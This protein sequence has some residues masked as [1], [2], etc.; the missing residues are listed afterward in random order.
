[1]FLCWFNFINSIN[2]TVGFLFWFVLIFIIFRILITRKLVIFNVLTG[3]ICFFSQHR[4]MH[5]SVL[6]QVVLSP[7]QSFAIRAFILLPVVNIYIVPFPIPCLLENFST[8]LASMMFLLPLEVLIKMR[9]LIRLEH[10][11]DHRLQYYPAQ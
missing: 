2:F 9:T 7:K 5:L 10:N 11:S 6:F 1:M 4:M 8:F 3:R